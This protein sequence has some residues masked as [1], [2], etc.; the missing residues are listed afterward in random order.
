MKPERW[1]R[2]EEIYHA[3]LER[4]EGQRAAFLEEACGR[5]EA[6]RREV[7]S[8]LAQEKGTGSFLE[9]PVLPVAAPGKQQLT[10]RRLVARAGLA[11]ALAL[12]VLLVLVMGLNLGA[13]TSVDRSPKPFGRIVGKPSL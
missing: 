4:G 9:A 12:A 10:R 3:A 5:D 8:L 6:L 13:I 11:A 2:V 7:E 1:Q